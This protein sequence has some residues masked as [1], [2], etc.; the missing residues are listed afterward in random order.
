MA[1]DP[2]LCNAFQASSAA[3]S[4][5]R[6]SEEMAA[7]LRTGAVRDL[8]DLYATLAVQ[9]GFF[10]A[11][12]LAAVGGARAVVDAE[13]DAVVD[14]SDVDTSSSCCGAS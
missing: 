11:V 9:T 13:V 8:A 3:A 14:A 4:L 5:L 10:V 7:L 6:T 12:R 1:F 2:P